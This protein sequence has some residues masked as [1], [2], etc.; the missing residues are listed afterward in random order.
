MKRTPILALLA[1]LVLGGAW[2][3]YV[4]LSTDSDD[5]AEAPAA[6]VAFTADDE[7]TLGN[8]ACG[9]RASISATK[10]ISCKVCPAGSDFAGNSPAGGWKDDG[11][12]TGSFTAPGEDE[13]LMHASGCESHA[14]NLGGDFL[15]R[16]TRGK[17]AMVRYAQGAPAN[18]D[19]LKS[20]WGDGR[21]A[22]ICTTSDMHQGVASMAVQ[23]M[24]FDAAEPAKE[25]SN[26]FHNVNFVVTEDESSNCGEP[27]GNPAMLQFDTIDRAYLMPSAT[28]RPSLS[29]KVTLARTKPGPSGKDTCPAA[30]PQSYTVN[31]KNLGDHFE[32]AEGFVALAGR[33]HDTCCELTVTQRVE[34]AKY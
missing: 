13:A 29:I 34:P 3:A 24:T 10:E 7:A 22:V 23:L 20:L 27:T 5:G 31:W 33:A 17:W 14:N 15:F 8:L 12:L 2:Y 25:P 26:D 19:C 9:G 1:V 21:D 4:A 30:T 6:Q 32:A 18:R 16:R 11:V 28:S